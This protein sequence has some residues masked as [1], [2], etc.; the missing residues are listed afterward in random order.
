MP[1]WRLITERADIADDPTHGIVP[2]D[3]DR[4]WTEVYGSMQEH[5]PVHRHLRRLVRRE[6]RQLDYRTA[7]DVG[8]GPGH[9]RALLAEGRELE[10]FGG[11]DISSVALEH[12]RRSVE[13]EF[14]QLDVERDVPPGSWDLVYCS[15]VM[16]HLPDDERALANL[17]PSVKRYLLLTTIAGN[18]DRYRAWDEQ[19]GHVRNYR[20]GQL[21]AKLER[22]GFR[23]VRST[24]WGFPF[25]SPIVRSLQNRSS[26]GTGK[27]GPVARLI[28]RLTYFVYFLNSSRRGDILIVLA[29]PK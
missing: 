25:Y 6:L 28:A 22:A 24:Y 29:V 10:R 26:F 19:M 21:E 9:N 5:G 18:F 7:L 23:V 4:V 17:R 14:W 16:E 1:P 15:L 2:P 12:A 20:R 11:V 8:C 3:Y 13:G 27:F